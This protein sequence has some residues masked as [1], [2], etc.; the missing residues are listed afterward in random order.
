MPKYFN[1]EMFCRFQSSLLIRDPAYSF[2]S[3]FKLKPDFI[4]EEGGVEGLYQAWK[5]LLE[6]G[7]SV[8]I[9]DATDIQRNP[10]AVVGAWCDAVG[11]ARMNNALR[12]NKGIHESWENWSQYVDTVKEST[13]FQKPP[14]SF[15]KVESERLAK[16]IDSARPLYREMESRKI[17]VVGVC[18]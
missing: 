16:M 17:T 4:Q 7:E 8:P 3:L 12:W 14:E 2:P 6:A 10:Q 9:I 1:K 11:I 13:G 15:P 5:I 18:E